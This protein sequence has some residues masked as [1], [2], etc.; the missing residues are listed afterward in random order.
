MGEPMVE[1]GRY[2]LAEVI[3]EGATGR[4][5]RA[6]RAGPMGFRVEVAIKQLRPQLAHEEAVVRAMVNEARVGGRLKHPNLVRVE[7]FDRVGELYYLAQEY[8]R[9]PTLSRV[10]ERAADQGPIPLRLVAEIGAQICAGLAHAH[11]ATDEEG[12]PLRLVHRDLKPANVLVG[13]DGIVKIADFGIAK[14]TNNLFQTTSTN[15]TKGT[16]SYMSPEQV[17]GGEL[18][19]RSDLF[20]VGAIVG[21]LAMGDQL[22]HHPNPTQTLRMVLRGKTG[23]FLKRLGR[24]S[25]AVRTIV[26]RALQRDRED[27]YP[28][29]GE[30]EKELRTVA[31][32]SP[33]A[34]PL[35]RWLAGWMKPSADR[36]RPPRVATP[37]LAELVTTG[38][39]PAEPSPP[40][41]PPAVATLKIET[42]PEANI[43]VLDD[44]EAGERRRHD[45]RLEL[46]RVPAG[47]LWMGS[48]DGE[49]GRYGDEALH[50]VRITRPF[51]LADTPVTQSQ[52]VQVMG[53]NPSRV[54]GFDHPADMISWSDAVEFCNRAS[55]LAGLAP[56]YR[57]DKRGVSWDRAAAG[58]RLPT[59]AEWELAARAGGSSLFAGGETLDDVAWHWR[60]AE[61]GSRPVRGLRANGYGLFDM[62]GNVWEWVWDW[63]APFDGRSAEAVD[64]TGPPEGGRRVARG[65]SWFSLPRDLRIACRRGGGTPGE[66]SAFRGLRIA[67]NGG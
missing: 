47:E 46:A 43:L 14:A 32:A 34:P 8:V 45:F 1:F 48:H 56:A 26:E 42:L 13:E 53:D 62:S 41:G 64:P 44:R 60:N 67:R 63:Y 10:I 33:E 24:R 19:H 36:P 9:G 54:A 18:D 52:W 30:L 61:A 37:N 16:P 39:G 49:I 66:H 11:Q 31:E 58:F 51:Q 23:P 38:S 35:E 3:G 55:A 25:P 59:E 50:R 27:R 7:E 17:M 57:L 6:Y 21:E 40:S 5:F 15:I 20:S 2:Q 22:F 12:Q 65:G 4:V 28:S 29:A